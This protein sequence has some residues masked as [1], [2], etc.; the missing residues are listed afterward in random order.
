MPFALVTDLRYQPIAG[1][2]R[3]R[4]TATRSRWNHVNPLASNN[5][6]TMMNF[7]PFQYAFM[8]TLALAQ[9]RAAYTC[10][11]IGQDGREEVSAYAT[12]WLDRV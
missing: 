3:A 11:T 7:N 12:S 8:N 9:Q 6:P 4:C 1:I 2:D 10:F 5:I